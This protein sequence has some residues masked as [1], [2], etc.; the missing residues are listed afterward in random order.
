MNKNLIETL[1][2]VIVVD[3]CAD[4]NID[5]EEIN[6]LKDLLDQFQHTILMPDI[7]LG[8][9]LWG[10]V[11]GC[12]IDKS[13]DAGIGIPSWIM[14]RFELR[15]LELEPSDVENRIQMRKWRPIR[16]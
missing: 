1:G 11:S 13:K 6:S 4:K 10:L 8:D 5:H 16:T 12:Y 9:E 2:K 3:A 14:A 15:G 7:H